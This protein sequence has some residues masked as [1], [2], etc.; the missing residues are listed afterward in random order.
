MSLSSSFSNALSGLKATSQMAQVVSSNVA[1]AMT[2]GYGR[3]QV[4]LSVRHPFGGVQVDGI[5]RLVDRGIIADRRMAESRMSGQEGMVKSLSRLENLMGATGSDTSLASRIVALERAF[6]SAAGDPSS[7]VRLALAGDRLADVVK[8][9]HE[10]ETGI[11]TLRQEADRSIADQVK[12][13]NTALVE[14]EDLNRDIARGNLTGA[15]TAGLMDR[16]QIAVDRIASIVPIREMDRANGTIALVTAQGATLLDGSV[17]RIGFTATPTI[18]PDMT[19]ASGALS[20]LTINGNLVATP[21]GVGKLSGGTLGASFMLRDDI[22]VSAQ[23]GL[24]AVARDLIERFS[25]PVADPTLLPGSPGLLTDAGLAFDPMNAIGLAGRIAVN[26]AVDPARGGELFRLRDGAG[27]TTPGPVGDSTRI[28]A[29]LAALATPRSLATGGSPGSAAVLAAGFIS[30]IGATRLSAEEVLAFSSARWTGLRQSELAMGVD[31]DA[32]M[33]NLLL[34][35]QSYAAN[36][37]VIQTLDNLMRVLM[38][39]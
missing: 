10:A 5:S 2:D 15:D 19:H 6:I 35:E 28:D 20:G 22:L 13:L 29:W 38:E 3:R 34:I 31:T 16:R 1:N 39:L 24:D 37:R 26:A 7:N 25:N 32:E 11:R 23:A 9:L 33:Q 4:E 27:A 36:A 21:D 17:A 30:G 12:T 18:V 14:V 8:G